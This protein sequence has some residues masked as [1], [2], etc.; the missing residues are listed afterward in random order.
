MPV[1]CSLVT[2]HQS[3]SRDT[4]SRDVTSCVLTRM[5]LSLGHVAKRNARL[6]REAIANNDAR[7]SAVASSLRDTQASNLRA[8]M[9]FL[10]LLNLTPEQTTTFTATFIAQQEREAATSASQQMTIS[11]NN[12]NAVASAGQ[13]AQTRANQQVVSFSRTLNTAIVNRAGMRCGSEVCRNVINGGNAFCS[14]SNT[15]S[16]G[17]FFHSH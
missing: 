14:S 16:Y 6:L 8:I 4:S 11:N 7:S 9:Q 2:S 3:G 12:Q 10:P 15:C 1:S 17:T 5:E 13:A